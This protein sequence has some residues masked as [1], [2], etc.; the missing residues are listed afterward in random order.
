[1]AAATVAAA[2]F[3]VE[4]AAFVPAASQSAARMART[5]PRAQAE[6][7][8]NGQEE[9]Y[10]PYEWQRAAEAA[11]QGGAVDLGEL[12]DLPD[13]YFDDGAPADNT[14]G[15]TPAVATLSV[16]VRRV[17]IPDLPGDPDLLPPLPNLAT[18]GGV[19]LWQW[20]GIWVAIGLGFAIVG[21]GAAYLIKQ[22]GI[23][24][25]FADSLFGGTKTALTVIEVLFLTRILLAQFPKVKTTEMP[26]APVHYS[27]EW[28]L[29]PTRAVF[30]PEA[31]VDVSP[32]VWLMA[33]L[34][35]QE[36]L[37]GPAGILL[38]ARNSLK[39]M[40]IR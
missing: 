1:M 39:P 18:D 37:T 11:D 24:P 19:G 40:G 23:D 28:I 22:A 29:A 21:G 3:A 2:V 12:P 33:A 14:G 16:K 13:L 38:M 27:T 4:N 10:R 35:A 5:G 36:L 31:G 25:V 34:L 26:W 8:E 30:P 20:T 6:G 17:E 7:K 9:S 15:F 32:I